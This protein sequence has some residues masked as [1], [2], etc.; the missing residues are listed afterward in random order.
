VPLQLDPFAPHTL[1]RIL[2]QPDFPIWNCGPRIL[3]FSCLR[4]KAHAGGVRSFGGESPAYLS[5][6][7]PRKEGAY[8]SSTTNHSTNA[9]EQQFRHHHQVVFMSQDITIQ[10]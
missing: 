8:A 2:C 7:Q 5:P 3:R 6:W 1:K 10:R 4:D 9:L